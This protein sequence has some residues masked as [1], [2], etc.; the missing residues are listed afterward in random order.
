MRP[1]TRFLS[2]FMSDSPE[3]PLAFLRQLRQKAASQ[4]PY[5]GAAQE[6]APR[7]SAI[8]CPNCGAPRAK[9]DGLVRCAYCN[10]EFMSVVIG[11][12]L[13]LKKGG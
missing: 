12:G 2:K 11:D 4:T 7:I 10:H 5:G 9:E 8:T 6:Q 1:E 3:K 13:H